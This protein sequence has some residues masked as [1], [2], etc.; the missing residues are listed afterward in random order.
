MTVFPFSD[1]SKV[2]PREGFRAALLL[3]PCSVH[4]G[5]TANI[6]DE[7]IFHAMGKVYPLT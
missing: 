7:L 3:S 4:S 2:L 1:G 6:P 5:R